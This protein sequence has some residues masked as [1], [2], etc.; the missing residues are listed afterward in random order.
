MGRLTLNVLL[1]F[2]Q[3]EREVTG[4]RIR[5]KIAASKAKGL[6]MGGVLPLGFD[7]P[8]EDKR[9][10]RVNE[11]EAVLVRRIFERYL[12]LRSVSLLN[13]WLAK[14]NI[15]PKQWTAR[16]GRK[17][18]ATKFNRGALYCLLRNPV[19]LGMIRHKSIVHPGAHA[20][21]VDVELFDRVQARLDAAAR[22]SKK[23]QES[24]IK[25]PLTGRIFDAAGRPMVPAASRGKG[26]KVYR[27]YATNK[28]GSQSNGA[29]LQRVPG[30]AIEDQLGSVLAR[31]FPAHEGNFLCLVRRVEVQSTAL[32]VHVQASLPKGAALPLRAGEIATVDP[33]DPDYLR[34]EL[35]LRIRSQ[36]GRTAI[37][38]ANEPETCFDEVMIAALRRAH[39]LIQLDRQRL[40]ILHEA[41]ASLYERRLV[42]LAFLAPDLQAAILAGRQPAHLKLEQVIERPIPIDWDEQRQIFKLDAAR[43]KLRHRSQASTLAFAQSVVDK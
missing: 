32:V 29:G 15:T 35:P 20:A 4:E 27:Y 1:S 22:R 41:P 42:R 23:K 14:E 33:V 43:S 39:S 10:L 21:I 5:D 38:L 24:K 40:P 2:A 30:A 25:A 37:Q 31:L 11:R 34:L 3:F 12:E 26:P 17:M 6:W 8:A 16:S 7:L 9:I 28:G 36:R 18:G 13:D 19:Y